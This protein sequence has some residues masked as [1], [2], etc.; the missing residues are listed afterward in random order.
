MPLVHSL[1]HLD[2]DELARAYAEADVF[3]FP[4]VADAWGLVLNEAMASGLPL[5]ATSVPGAVDDLLSG[6]ENGIVVPP[7]D[8]GALADAMVALASDPARRLE[9]GE[10]SSSRIR[11]FEPLTWAEGIREAVLAAVPNGAVR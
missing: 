2:R 3:V 8:P 9:M 1:G 10:R 5:I 11:D 4:S 6:G 7:F